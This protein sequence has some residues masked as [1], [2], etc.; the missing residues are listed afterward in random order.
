[1]CGF[2]GEISNN[3]LSEKGFRKLLDLS[4]KRGPDQQGFW[5][6][7]FCQLGFN[8]LSI[9]DVTENG[10][11]PL[12][13]PNGK[14]ALVFNGEV[15]N[16]KEIQAKYNIQEQDLRSHSD[17]EILA[18][19]I[20]K[21]EIDIFAKELNG[22]FAVAVYDILNKN[23]YLIRDFAGI[24]PLYYGLHS[25]G[26]IFAS[27]F[28]QIFN[29]P[30]F[31]D[32][33]LRPEIMKEYFALGYMSAPNTIFENIFQVEPG[34][35]IHWNYSE[36]RIGKKTKFWSWSVTE[37]YKETDEKTILEF[38]NHLNNIVKKQMNSDVP[39]ATFLS[40]GIDSP[41]ITYVSSKIKKDIKAFTIAVD[42]KQIN[43]GEVAKEYAK[44]MNVEHHIETFEENDLIQII[45]EH[46]VA[47][48]EPFGDFSSIPSYLITKKAK[49]FATVMLS[50]D[51][52]D[53]LFWGYPRFI[54]STKQ[55][56][57]FK[58]PLSLRKII[59]P[60]ARK[61]KKDLSYALDS[62]K[63]FENWILSKQAYL[64]SNKLMPEY[65]F[66]EELHKIYSY[67]HSLNKKDVLLFLKE[68][69]FY[70]HL[71][72]ILKKVD[73]T[74]ME[75]SLEV[76]VP[77]LDKEMMEFSNQ[78]E[79]QLTIKHKKPKYVLRKNL[80]KKVSE[81]LVN[82]PK[83][84]FTVPLDKWLRNELKE[85]VINELLNKPF[86]GSEYISENELKNMVNDFYERKSN[87]NAWGIWHLYSWAKWS[88]NI[89]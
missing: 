87:I 41:L 30:V 84:G 48:K 11:Q 9:I 81:D 37:K 64:K 51:G 15:Y 27:Q 17:S 38:E 53:E 24:K 45:N 47:L 25:D 54:K 4:I 19:L 79:P 52:G 16:Y 34:Q 23:I 59:L 60:F 75:N 12:L 39:L 88:R 7:N 67:N 62:E 46:F 33:K 63:R 5:K 86:Y 13:S 2:I 72:R 61:V 70:G 36:K 66:S 29:H 22:M 69:E 10:K 80:S 1:M 78:I 40:G 68:N 82:L 83:R 18:H 42:D 28:D 35:I 21:T 65:S 14:F 32:K 57:W 58:I 43:E 76:R 55:A 49:E 73:L 71:Q 89:H 74:S 50:G 26:I 77:F 6:D 44:Q 8:R 20:E 3:L 31:K 56:K 85:D